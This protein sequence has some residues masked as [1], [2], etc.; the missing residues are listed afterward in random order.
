MN[1]KSVV[2]MAKLVQAV[3][4]K[5]VEMEAQLKSMKCC[6]NCKNHTT[7]ARYDWCDVANRAVLGGNICDKWQPKESK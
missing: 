7:V 4:E 2:E 1:N 6:G 5:N 3:S